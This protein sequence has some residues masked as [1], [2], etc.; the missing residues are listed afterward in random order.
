MNLLKEYIQETEYCTYCPMM[1]RFSCPVVS[2]DAQEAHAPGRKL[3]LLNLLRK[4]MA[5]PS[6]GVSEIFYQCTECLRC[7]TYC[8]HDIKPPLVLREAKASMVGQGLLGDTVKRAVEKARG[9]YAK[10]GNF[11]G[12][13]LAAGLRSLIPP[14]FFRHGTKA[15]YFIGCV[16]ARY[17]PATA[18]KALDILRGSGL[19]ISLY[20]GPV[21]CSGYPYLTLGDRETFR[22]IARRNS[23]I[24][25]SYDTVINPCPACV[26]TLSEAYTEAGFPV[27]AGVLH[28]ASYLHRLAREGRISPGS[29]LKKKAGY[30]DPCF[31]GRH[32]GVYD[33]P[34]DLLKVA[35]PDGFIEAQASGNDASCCGAGGGLPH[36]SPDTAGAIALERVEEFTSQ[37]AEVIVT[38]CPSCQRWLEKT[39]TLKVMDILE[40]F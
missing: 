14:E 18:K 12:L 2:N 30:H 31:L 1:C 13:D 11:F 24:L 23:E 26:H 34:R 22:T 16:Q 25:N 10:A 6:A 38:A 8:V 17:Y 21:M 33:A 15:L 9:N 19:D 4:G 32:L 37:G 27:K 5:E 3:T 29:S 35:A 7:N 39:D 28:I 36:T 20:S 40:L